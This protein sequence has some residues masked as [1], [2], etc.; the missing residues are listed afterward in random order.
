MFQSWVGMLETRAHS[1]AAG[2]SL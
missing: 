1:Y 2:Q